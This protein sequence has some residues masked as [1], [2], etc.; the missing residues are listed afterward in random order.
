M[1]NHLL[2]IQRGDN[3]TDF[4]NM[5]GNFFTVIGSFLSSAW[6]TMIMFFQTLLDVLTI[7]QILTS[8]T[9]LPSIITVS[10]SIVMV[11]GVTKL[12]LSIL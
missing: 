7:P 9:L 5:I 12:I 8:G 6:A 2:V 4:F 11:V 1:Q 3:M 10:V